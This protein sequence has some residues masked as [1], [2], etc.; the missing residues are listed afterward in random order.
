MLSL[1]AALGLSAVG[2]QRDKQRLLSLAILLIS[3][4][5]TILFLVSGDVLSFIAALGL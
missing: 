2:V 4:A 1:I 5:L 3:G